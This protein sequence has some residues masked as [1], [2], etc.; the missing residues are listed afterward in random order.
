MVAHSVPPSVLPDI[1]PTRGEIGMRMAPPQTADVGASG[2]PQLISPLVGEMSGR[3]EGGN[4]R[5][6][7]ALCP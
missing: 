5:T 6:A 1:S 7:G 4:P 3:T 2:C